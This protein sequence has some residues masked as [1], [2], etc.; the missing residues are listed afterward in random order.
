M[1]RFFGQNWHNLLPSAVF[2]AAAVAISLVTHSVISFCKRWEPRIRRTQRISAG[3]TFR[4]E[5]VELC[6]H[7]ATLRPAFTN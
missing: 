3:V 4:F 2:P 7:D 1:V 6:R 5:G